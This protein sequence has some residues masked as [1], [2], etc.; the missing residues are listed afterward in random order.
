MADLGFFVSLGSGDGFL[1]GANGSYTVGLMVGRGPP[2]PTAGPSPVSG[3]LSMSSVL[4]FG[5][6]LVVDEELVVS[7]S[8]SFSREG[9]V[10]L[11]EEEGE[12]DKS[13]V[14]VEV[15]KSSPLAVESPPLLTP[16]TVPTSSGQEGMML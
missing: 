15:S 11:S 6:G 5:G 16:A 14:A 12:V 1:V 8:L 2:G 10:L 4:E 3:V 13:N 9:V 7:L